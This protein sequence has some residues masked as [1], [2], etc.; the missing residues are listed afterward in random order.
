MTA[1]LGPVT[2]Q[3]FFEAFSDTAL[4]PAKIAARLVGLDTDT[5]SE[6]TDEGLIRAVR[7]GR[8]RSYTE[9]DLRAYLLEGPDAPPRERKPKQVVAASRGRVVPFSKRA[10]AGKR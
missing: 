10:A 4:V 3:R 2:E 5:L 7:K 1:S 9:H 6:M 8:L